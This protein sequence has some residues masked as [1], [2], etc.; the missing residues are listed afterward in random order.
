MNWL[1][2]LRLSP[3][4]LEFQLGNLLADAVRRQRDGLSDEFL[5]GMVCHQRIDVFTETH[6]AV[7]ESRRRLRGVRGRYAGIVVD[8]LYDHFLSSGW[9]ELGLGDRDEFLTEFHRGAQAWDGFLP[10]G[11]RGTLDWILASQVL[12]GYAR[13][14]GIHDA[15]ARFSGRMTRRL[16]VEV[17]LTGAMDDLESSYDDLAADFARF[18]PEVAAHARHGA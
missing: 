13:A 7:R 12:S 2:H 4:S 10:D 14:D 15:L 11:A 6:P 9:T 18:W 17:D 16:G 1:A 5:R 3:P 8:I